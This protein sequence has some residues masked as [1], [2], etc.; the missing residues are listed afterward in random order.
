MAKRKLRLFGFEEEINNA[1]RKKGWTTCEQLLGLPQIE[2]IHELQL[3]WP[4]VQQITD[5]VSSR[6]APKSRCVAADPA[7]LTNS[8]LKSIIEEKHGTQQQTV[9]PTKLPLLDAYLRGGIPVGSV[10][11]VWYSLAFL[12][13]I[14]SL[15]QLVLV[16]FAI[17]SP[18]FL[19]DRLNF[20]TLFL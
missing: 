4:V 6:I 5:T 3:P 18:R 2:V 10:T 15:V 14:R 19:T 13:Q 7:W 17:R 20:A 9:V 1:F 16:K 12:M 8:T 11:E